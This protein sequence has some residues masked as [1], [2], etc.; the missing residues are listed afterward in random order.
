MKEQGFAEL[1]LR[2]LRTVLL[3]DVSLAS[4]TGL[5]S[6]LLGFR[7]VEAYATALVWTGL[8]LMFIA[9]LT[10]AGGLSARAGDVGAYARSGAGNMSENLLQMAESRRSS[11]GCL[12]TLLVAGL[13][14]TG[15]GYLL[16][17]IFSLFG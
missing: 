15:T 9:A 14:L 13:G 1:I 2:F 12:F 17:V 3:I 4:V 7:T 11:L 8:V 5:L 10:G 6:F 16:P